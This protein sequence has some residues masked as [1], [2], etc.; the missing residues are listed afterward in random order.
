MAVLIFLFVIVLLRQFRDFNGTRI[1]AAGCICL[2][3]ALSFGN[4][5]GMIAKYNIDRYQ[6]G[7]LKNLDVSAL[8]ELSDGAVPYL[9]EY[10]GET[11]STAMK[12]VLK[13]VMI[14]PRRGYD[15]G[16]ADFRDFNLQKY[17]ADRIR[18]ELL[19]DY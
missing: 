10:Y 16:E 6:A 3:L 8:G 15:P 11:K 14:Q 19:V 2:F 12:A 18:L 5:D 13:R 7:T 4:V 9:Y 1:A 17:K